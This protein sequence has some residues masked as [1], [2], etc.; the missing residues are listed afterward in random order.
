VL[1]LLEVNTPVGIKGSGER[2]ENA[3]K[4]HG[5]I[6]RYGKDGLSTSQ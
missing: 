1:K 6:L 2:R 5:A 4:E 3:G